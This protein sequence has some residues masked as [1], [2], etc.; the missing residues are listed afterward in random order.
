MHL[1]SSLY[2]YMWTAGPLCKICV[3]YVCEKTPKEVSLTV[4]PSPQFLGCICLL[5][6]KDIYVVTHSLAKLL[7]ITLFAILESDGRRQAS[8][9]RPVSTTSNREAWVDHS[10]KD[11]PSGEKEK[12]PNH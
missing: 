12:T 8:D 4:T 11:Y 10:G 6:G 2:S 1:G 7:A 3:Y 5:D 9:E